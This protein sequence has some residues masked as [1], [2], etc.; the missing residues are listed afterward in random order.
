MCLYMFEPITWSFSGS[1]NTPR[2]KSQL[3]TSF[4]SC[5]STVLTYAPI[6]MK[7]RTSYSH[8]LTKILNVFLIARCMLLVLLS[9]TP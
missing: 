2:S 3:L 7:R 5:L 1:P 6:S 9:S 4:R 8:F